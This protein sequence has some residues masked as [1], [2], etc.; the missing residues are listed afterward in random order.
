MHRIVDQT[1]TSQEEMFQV[2]MKWKS[3]GKEEEN[4]EITKN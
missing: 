1:T 4:S 3:A 2:M